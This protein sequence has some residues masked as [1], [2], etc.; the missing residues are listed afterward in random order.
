MNTLLHE[1]YFALFLIV[2]L[3][4][5]LGQLE[6]RGISLDVSAVIFVALVFGHY[7]IKVPSD[8]Q[9]IGLILFIY[10]VGLQSGSG[11]FD[12][13]RKHGRTLLLMGAIIV[14]SGAGVTVLCCKIFGID[15]KLGA[16]LLAGGLTSTPGL[17]AAI[18]STGSSPL[19]SIGY[20]VA[21]PFGV[22]GVI[23]F[24]RLLP[25]F[26]GADIAAAAT[27]WD[28]EA[29]AEYP[30]IFNANFVV[31]NSNIHGQTIG[32]LGIAT[33][34]G[35]HVSRVLHAGQAFTPSKDTR[36]HVGDRIKAVGTRKALDKVRLLVGK[37]T[38]EDIPLSQDHDVKWVL[39]T[40]KDVV[41]KTLGQINLWMVYSATV[42]RIRRSGVD[43]TP[44]ANTALRF[45]D[46]LM[47]A[48]N[49]DNLGRVARLLGNDERCLSETN[50]LPIA[51]GIVLGVLLG[52]F[53]IPA[54]SFTF[55]LGSTGGV[56]AAGLI[57]SRLGKTGPIL[58]S[59]SGFSNQ[60]MR[61]LGLLFFLA[62]VGTEAGE[63]L[64]KVITDG[65]WNLIVV[66]I[67]I[68]V[69]PMVVAAVIGHFVLRMNFLS[70]LG[71]IAG[72]MT[73]TPGLAA[74]DPLTDS[75]APALAYATVYP[76]ALVGMVVACQIV[77]RL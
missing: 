55:A 24:L 13:F 27:D 38:D 60:F 32:E 18:E 25:K 10:S 46:K 51:L 77:A 59:M 56:L 8:F 23:V 67:L 37:P 4:M 64:V 74:V 48:S 47:I 50:F 71:V 22:L 66:S 65:G 30:E 42:T 6:V 19:A 43:I 58:W 62:A 39:V 1:G 54:G 76:F 57:L 14:A 33:M 68:A 17:A 21:Y 44:N 7:G 45:G 69:M 41:G 16:G 75:D 15:S 34:T 36:L 9:K 28:R 20:G 2:A 52:S 70:L 35:A 49:K 11:F 73:S 40:N 72:G 5:W 26:L 12:A 61:E 31:E 29:K 53:A 63:H 3:G